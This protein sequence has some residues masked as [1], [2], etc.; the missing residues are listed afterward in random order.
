[1]TAA[2]PTSL[3][4]SFHYVNLHASLETARQ[5]I[6]TQSSHPED[7]AVRQ[8]HAEIEACLEKYDR[9][10]V[11]TEGRSAADGAD[12]VLR[13]RERGDFLLDPAAIGSEP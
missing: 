3:S 13:G 11:E 6:R 10:T 4:F 2:E 9:H 1:L 12:R 5:R 8:M 7:E